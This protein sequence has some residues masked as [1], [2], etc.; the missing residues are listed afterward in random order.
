MA[1]AKSSPV[2]AKVVQSNVSVRKITNG[3]VIR[4]TQEMSNGR[5]NEK[6][7]FS[8][9]NPVVITKPKVAKK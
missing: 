8:T 6:E 4:E 3:F 2:R 1:K 9:T 5:W 7:T